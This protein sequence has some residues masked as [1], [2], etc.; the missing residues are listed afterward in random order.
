MRHTL[1]NDVRPQALR[2]RVDETG[3]GGRSIRLSLPRRGA[4]TWFGGFGV[5]DATRYG[6]RRRHCT[7]ELFKIMA[8]GK[9]V[10]AGSSGQHLALPC[11]PQ[12]GNQRDP[13][14]GPLERSRSTGHSRPGRKPIYPTAPVSSPRSSGSRVGTFAS[15]W[16]FGDEGRRGSFRGPM[17]HAA[18]PKK[19][20]EAHQG[21]VDEIWQQ[22]R[23]MIRENIGDMR[24]ARRVV[25]NALIADP[26][27]RE[28]LDNSVCGSSSAPTC[29][30]FGHGQNPW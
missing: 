24:Q 23:P 29:G 2:C 25:R 28:A 18:A 8:D 5:P 30:L 12:S 15:H 14:T 3:S 19:L 4:L 17:H 20:G 9:S 16:M 26:F 21:M 22:H 10:E 1:T 6:S 11:C 27:D 13:A 7:R